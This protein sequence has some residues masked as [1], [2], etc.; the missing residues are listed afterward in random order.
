VEAWKQQ[1]L[2]WKNERQKLEKA[3]RDTQEAAQKLQNEEDEGAQRFI[4]EMGEQM[5][6][7]IRELQDQLGKIQEEMKRL[8]LEKDNLSNQLANV[9]AQYEKGKL[10]R[11][12]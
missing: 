2:E 1:E 10:Y 12:F 8:Q 5:N 3:L 6:A 11:Y 9:T 4:D 7:A